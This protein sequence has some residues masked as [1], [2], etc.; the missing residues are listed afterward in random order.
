MYRPT[1]CLI[2]TPLDYR[3][4]ILADFAET[5]DT[6]ASVHFILPHPIRHSACQ[7][8][9]MFRAEFNGVTLLSAREQ[10]YLQ[11]SA[12][13]MSR[14]IIICTNRQTLHLQVLDN[15]YMDVMRGQ[16]YYP[17]GVWTYFTKYFT[18]HLCF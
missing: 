5:H 7:N 15:A 13:T 10:D 3:C 11:D 4:S 18:Y 6:T 17:S 14:D 12:H 16:K 8:A 9:R 1:H 2:Q